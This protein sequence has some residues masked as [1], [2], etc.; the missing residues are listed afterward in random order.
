[1]NHAKYHRLAGAESTSVLADDF[2]ELRPRNRRSSDES[3]G[4]F[5]TKQPT[6]NARATINHQIND[7]ETLAQIALKY[8]LQASKLCHIVYSLFYILDCRN[9]T[10]K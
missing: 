5:A 7:G 9:K 3:Q 1:M 4:N 2:I 8:S 6:T 10:C